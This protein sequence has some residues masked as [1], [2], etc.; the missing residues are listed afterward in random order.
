MITKAFDLLKMIVPAEEEIKNGHFKE[1]RDFFQEFKDDK[2][3][4]GPLKIKKGPMI[5]DLS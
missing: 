1:A 3:I 2:K 5:R 4:N